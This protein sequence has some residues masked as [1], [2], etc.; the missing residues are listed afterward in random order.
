MSRRSLASFGVLLTACFFLA[1]CASKREGGCPQVVYLRDLSVASDYARSEPA[2]E[3]LVSSARIQSLEGSC[4]YGEEG[5]NVDFTLTMQAVKG[6]RL[7]GQEVSFPFFVAIVKP[8]DSILAKDVMTASFAFKEGEKT[9]LLAQP[10]HIFIPLGETETANDYRV[11]SGFQLSE[12]E[13]A[14]A[15]AAGVRKTD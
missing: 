1:A 3:N 6:P 5:L 14:L 4:S 10:L 8:D 13:L 12:A 7:G 9:A 2:P 11:L 15:R